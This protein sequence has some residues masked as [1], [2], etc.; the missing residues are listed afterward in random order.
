MLNLTELRKNVP[1]GPFDIFPLTISEYVQLLDITFAAKRRD[2]RESELNHRV[3]ANA[4]LR[5]LLKDVE[6]GDV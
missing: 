2:N 1:T 4:E 6:I 5:E 3:T